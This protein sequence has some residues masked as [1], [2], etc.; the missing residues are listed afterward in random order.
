[1]RDVLPAY[2]RKQVEDEEKKRATKSMSVRIMSP[3]EQHLGVM[4]YFRR[5]L[6]VPEWMISLKNSVHFEVFGETAGG[7][8]LGLKDVE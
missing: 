8:L 5:N 2:Q 7:H 6:R 3:E 1:M 4:E